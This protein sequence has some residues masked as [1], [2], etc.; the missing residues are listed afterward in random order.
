MK[1]SRAWCLTVSCLMVLFAT[2]SATADGLDEPIPSFYE[3]AGFAPNH[4]YVSQ[5]PSEQV[6][7]FSGKLKLNYVDLFIPGNGG[8]DIKIQRSYH[9]VAETPEEATPYGVGWS[10]NFGRVLRKATVALCDFSQP[11]TRAPVLELADGSRQILYTSLS[12]DSYISANLW[13][14]TCFG[15]GTGLM[16]YSPDG[17][18]YQM[19]VAGPTVGTSQTTAQNAYYVSRITDRN[20]NWLAFTYA[21]IGASYGISTITSSDGRTV[22]F[23]YSATASALSTISD[24]TRTW[25]YVYQ[26][27]ANWTGNGYYNLKQVIRPDGASWSYEYNDYSPAGAPGGYSIKQVT[28]PTGGTL[29]Y[30]YDY[31]YF[32]LSPDIPRS[33][34][35][36]QKVASDGASINTW[37][38]A[39]TPA[40]QVYAS[41]FYYPITGADIPQLDRTT[42]SGPDGTHIHYHFGYGSAPPGGVYAIG[43]LCGLVE[44]GTQISAYSWAPQQISSQ[45][46]VRPGGTLTF[47]NATFRPLI[48][49]KNMNRNGQ[50]YSTTYGGFDGF[51][52]PTTITEQ[53]TE[54]QPRQ[55]TKSYF[56]NTSAWIINVPKEETI[57]VA[58][59]DVSPTIGREF[60]PNG[61]KLS[62]SRNGVATQFTYTAQGD[63]ATRTDAR[64]AVSTTTY[65]DYFRG[66]PRLENQPEGVSIS[67]TVSNAGNVTSQTDGEAATTSY[68]YDGLNRLTSIAHPLGNPVTVAWTATSRTV[69]R[70]SYQEITTFDPFGRDK[71]VKHIDSGSG[72]T[73]V[74]NYRY[75]SVGRRTFASYPNS[76]LGTGFAFDIVGQPLVIYHVYDP[77]AQTYQGGH[78]YYY[79]Y[80]TVKLTNERGLEYLYTYRAFGSPDARDLMQVGSPEPGTDVAM[81]RNALGGLTRVTQG[82]LSRSYGYDSHYF[83]TSRADPE[84]GTTALGRDEIGNLSSRHVGS[85]PTVQFGYD[86]LSRLKTI[87]YA[88][89]APN[90]LKTY[91]KDDKIKSVDNG[92]ARRDYTYDGN[93]NLTTESLSVDGRNFAATYAYDGN[94]ALSGLTYGSGS[95]VQYAPDAFGRPTKAAPYV[96]ALSRHST[97]KISSM[98]YANGV[99]TNYGFN[100]RNWPNTIAIGKPNNNF[101]SSSYGYD[102]LGNVSSI[103][104]SIYSYYSRTMSYDNIDRLTAANGPWIGSSTGTITYDAVGNVKTLTLGGSSLSYTYNP[105]TNLLQGVSGSKTATYSYDP[106]GNVVGDG[107]TTF[108]Y[109]DASTMQCAK[110]ASADQVLYA[111]D[112]DKVRVRTQKSGASTYFMQDRSGHL[113][114]ELTPGEKVTEYVYLAGKQVA[115]RQLGAGSQ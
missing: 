92:V 29:S 103:S 68:G 111:Y 38:Y 106:R 101:V 39:Y 51:G 104:D 83:L 107:S 9:S 33:T 14:A 10:M 17:T 113:L 27:V 34:V 19:D 72:E 76:A 67:R 65:S 6:D 44:Q 69:A 62:E 21:N 8:M 11:S 3:E 95:A 73:I 42:I 86:G 71:Q 82:S 50:N 70:G 4:D 108:N 30:S 66:I 15:A 115:V 79:A 23:T 46:N 94:D 74:Q 54:S 87:T 105:A 24:G 48:T 20:G 91:Y 25:T 96:T 16:V 45:A 1:Y 112:G 5:H 57:V 61:N 22:T 56:A 93:K 85:G 36:S 77:A 63:L 53:G 99:I 40:T 102:G 98:T 100:A 31:V 32:T 89:N 75:D 26:P 12:N 7:P 81:Q 49:A 2:N 64:G 90:V 109:D 88:G 52:N 37:T 80:N 41:G 78:S 97:G 18:R 55:V 58:Q 47:D 110:C 28:Y 114:W 59:P 84:I 43:L 13:A 60:D 35:V